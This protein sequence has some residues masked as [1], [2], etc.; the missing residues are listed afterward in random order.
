[1]RKALFGDLEDKTSVYKATEKQVDLK[2]LR[3][4]QRVDRKEARQNKNIYSFSGQDLAVVDE[5]L[6]EEIFNVH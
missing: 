3:K 4:D 1:M 5:G 2:K 6:Q